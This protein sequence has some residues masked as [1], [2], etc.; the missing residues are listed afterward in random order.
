MSKKVTCFLPC[1]QG[2]QR[3]PKKNIK[4]FAG[5]E[6]GLI[7]IKL[8]QLLAS[9]RIDEVVLSTNDNAIIE[10]AQG[11]NDARLNIH[12][13]VDALALSS[14][15]T[16]D[17]VA[18]A[19]SLIV[20][21]HILWTHVT[22]PFINEE[23][24]DEI[25][26]NYFKHLNNGFDSLMTTTEIYS[27]LWQDGAPLNYNRSKEKWPRTQ[28]LEPVQE[29]NSGAFLAPVSVYNELDDRI[30]SSVYLHPLDKLVS[31]DIDWPEDFIIAECLVEKGLVM[32]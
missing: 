18:H 13:R 24:Y 26:D 31:H 8:K 17:L 30:G 16:D 27:F 1:R 11:I 4:P 7:E 5:F 22:S 9:T 2:S 15:S 28:T 21:G 3:V 32:L 20:E 12:R 29:V 10:Y 25:I 23:K 14:T 6:F 19:A